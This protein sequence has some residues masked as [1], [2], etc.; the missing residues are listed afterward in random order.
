MSQSELI[1][2]L[3]RNVAILKTENRYN[4]RIDHELESKLMVFNNVS[5][6]LES[7]LDS[8]WNLADARYP[9]GNEVKQFIDKISNS[10][11]SINRQICDKNSKI[12]MASRT[13]KG[14]PLSLLLDK[15][16]KE[17]I[18]LKVCLQ[19]N[20]I[21]YNHE[22][23]L[24]GCKL[25]MEVE[26]LLNSLEKCDY[27]LQQYLSISNIIP[28]ITKLES[29]VDKYVSNIEL[30]PVQKSFLNDLSTFSIVAK[31]LTGE[32][33]GYEQLDPNHILTENIPKKPVLI[34]K[35]VK[36]KIICPC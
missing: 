8:L 2:T 7:K 10:W 14:V 19:A 23:A 17:V 30:L 25:I 5:R 11:T 13:L 15:V 21:S 26:R 24:E 28:H 6:G 34:I 29:M 16:K 27:K 3:E 18:L 33:L 36:R 31:L 35:N 20:D 22:H 9:E 4:L 1:N 32:L 12:R